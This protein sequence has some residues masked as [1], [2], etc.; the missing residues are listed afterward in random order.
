M[1]QTTSQTKNVILA[2]GLAILEEFHRSC[3][4]FSENAD[5]ISDEIQDYIYKS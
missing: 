2:L 1:F 4:M 3:W 5:E